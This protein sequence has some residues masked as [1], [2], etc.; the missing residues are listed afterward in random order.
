MGIKI[1]ATP[2]PGT[3][4]ML[5]DGLDDEYNRADINAQ[6]DGYQRVKGYISINDLFAKIQAAL[7]TNPND[8]LEI[9]EINAHGNPGICNGFTAQNIASFG[10]QLA[11]WH[12]ATR[13]CD[14][15]S[16]YFTGCNTGV[17]IAGTESLAQALSRLTPTEAGG[18]VRI[19]VYG[20]VGY[21]SGSHM[22]GDAQTVVGATVHGN[23]FA[24]YPSTTDSQGTNHPGSTAATGAASYR[25]YREGRP[26]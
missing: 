2:D 11:T 7:I 26:I 6:A 20:S 13:L 4:G 8:C 21:I 23:Y 16:I 18:N 1:H 24:P 12:Q 25:G 3:A 9:I 17:R 10:S 5:G 15:V 22:H 19:N 14:V